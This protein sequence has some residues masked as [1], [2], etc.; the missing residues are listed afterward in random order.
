ML[1]RYESKRV[2]QFNQKEYESA[3]QVKLARA[4]GIQTLS[5]SVGKRAGR[6]IAET[7]SSSDECQEI[8]P[9]ILRMRR[10]KRKT[11]DTTRLRD[12]P[13]FSASRKCK[14]KVETPDWNIDSSVDEETDGESPSIRS[15]T[16]QLMS[17]ADLSK[18]PECLR[19]PES[20]IKAAV[21]RKR[22]AVAVPSPCRTQKG[23]GRVR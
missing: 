10:P 6:E 22:A 19:T 9:P 3:R 2:R 20:A 11:V 13:E 1:L 18:L 7:E 17:M 8:S 14:I 5:A 16:S 23:K 4:P 15:T 21:S 12:N